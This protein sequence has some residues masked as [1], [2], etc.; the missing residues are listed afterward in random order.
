MTAPVGTYER[1]L[2]L[3]SAD[4]PPAPTLLPW[5]AR[6]AAEEDLLRI[7]RIAAAQSA[8]APRRRWPAVADATAEVLAVR[9]TGR[10]QLLSQLAQVLPPV[11]AY[12]DE[13]Q[14]VALVSIGVRVDAAAYVALVHPGGHVPEPALE[15]LHP[16][17]RT[18][19]TAQR[20]SLPPLANL[21]LLADLAGGAPD[22]A[23]LLESEAVYL[24]P[25]LGAERAGEVWAQTAVTE[26][27]E[28]LKP[29]SRWYAAALFAR[30]T[31]YLGR[32]W[33][34]EVRDRA[35]TLPPEWA[36][37]FDRLWQRGGAPWPSAVP[38]IAAAHPA[39]AELDL[40]ADEA[41]DQVARACAEIADRMPV[42]SEQWEPAPAVPAP[43]VERKRPTTFAAPDREDFAQ[44]TL[45]GPAADVG[46]GERAA[47]PGLSTRYRLLVF[48]CAHRECPVCP[49]SDCKAQKFRIYYDDRDLPVCDHDG[50]RMVLADEIR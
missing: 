24:L 19:L 16:L 20:A 3:V 32:S 1:I 4:M 30:A 40:L 12:L 7:A 42:A 22:P 14:A 27:G 13:A 31:P 15:S 50:V 18:V 10:P 37:V 49:Q 46:A 44:V 26:I 28:S 34:S 11:M 43:P 48:S 17:W 5:L 36:E 33:R 2:A 8:L 9:G 29:D 47:L 39:M 35:A 38:E 25:F 21:R 6:G 41:T 45:G 23:R